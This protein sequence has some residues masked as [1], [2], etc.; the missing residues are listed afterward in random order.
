MSLNRL[1]RRPD[2]RGTMWVLS[3]E[4]CPQT[5]LAWGVLGLERR[6]ERSVYTAEEGLDLTGLRAVITNLSRKRVDAALRPRTAHGREVCAVVGRFV[7]EA[8]KLPGPPAQTRSHTP[9]GVGRVHGGRPRRRRRGLLASA[10]RRTRRHCRSHRRGHDLR[11]RSSQRGTPP[12][13]RKD[14]TMPDDT[15]QRVTQ[16]TAARQPRHAIA[17][18]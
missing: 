3:R 2:F 9:H 14:H 16:T 15:L 7:P 6:E 12:R 5:R 8:S 17:A 4:R 1:P 11:R 10:C 18:L 13:V